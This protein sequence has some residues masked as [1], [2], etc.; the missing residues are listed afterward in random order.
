MPKLTHTA[1]AGTTVTV[2]EDRAV[3]LLASDSG[4]RRVDVPRVPKGV[5]RSKSQAEH[6]RRVAA[7]EA[8]E[9]VEVEVPGE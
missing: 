2:S 3:E 7:L 8:I 1:L 9:V 5:K 6:G 4:Y